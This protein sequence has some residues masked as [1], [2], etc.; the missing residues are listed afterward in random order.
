MRI[1]E[2][3]PTKYGGQDVLASSAGNGW[4]GIVAEH[5]RHPKGE[6]PSFQPRHM[7]IGI[8][9]GCH[10]DCIVGRTGGR[11]RQHTRVEP[12][13]IWLCPVGVMEEDIQI[14]EWHDVLHLYLPPERF[15]ELSEARGGAAARAGDRALPRRHL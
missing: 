2:H 10:P 4:H 12:G 8:A 5:R 3:G 6:L 13:T 11:L 14:S 15:A 1:Q 9:T 7:E